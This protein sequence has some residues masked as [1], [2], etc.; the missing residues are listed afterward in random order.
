[1]SKV[2]QKSMPLGEKSQYKTGYDANLLFPIARKDNRE[3]LGIGE[4]LPFFGYDIWNAYELSWLN[5]KGKPEIAFAEFI[6]TENS[7]YIIESKSLKLYL[8]SF[9]NSRFDGPQVVR[10]TI[11]RDL[12]EACGA[13]VEVRFFN[14]QQWQQ[15]GIQKFAATSIDDLDIEINQYTVCPELLQ[16]QGDQVISEKLCSNLL[17]SNC[18]V[19]GQPDWG[20]IYIEYT[21]LQI[22]HESLLRYIISFRNHNEFAEPAV[23]RIFMDI[24]RQCQPKRLIIY[25][26][27]TRRGGLDINPIRSNEQIQ[28]PENLRL[29]RQ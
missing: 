9:N 7:P 27:Y 26:R 21:G 10:Q 28:L 16:I 1:M 8:N 2:T 20:S 23:E 19:T 22:D 29:F 18:L 3:K 15:L 5:L 24:S 4:S 25:G 13:P 6:F 14:E 17:K 11:T 12:S